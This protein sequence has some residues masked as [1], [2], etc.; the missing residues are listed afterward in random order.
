MPELPEVETVRRIF[1]RVLLGETIV[2][3]EI[4]EDDI[5]LKKTP[6]ATVKEAVLGKKVTA[7][8]RRGKYFWLELESKPW[9]FG[10][11]GMAGWVR[12][13]GAPT[14]RLREHGNAPF[15]DENGQ[16][17]FL[18]MGLESSNGKRLVMTDGRR[19]ARIW[20]CE[21]P[22]AD[23][24]I[25]LLSPDWYTDPMSP[26]EVFDRIKKKSAPMK[27]I[28]LD[29]SHFAGVGNWIADEV[30]YQ[31]RIR[32]D[33]LGKDL[34]IEETRELVRHL[35]NILKQAID[36]GADSEQFPKSWLFHYRW[37]GKKGDDL[38]EGREI[39][40]DQIGGR[41]TAWVPAIQ[42]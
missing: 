19:L 10:H 25:S 24:A 14:I 8:G 33:R 23:K 20:L 28:L 6:S 1:E 40:R 3:A 12:E 22:E 36:L 21:S 5:V 30:L 15:E 9:L 42:R 39:Q 38:I 41:T 29:Q 37:G 4:A 34:S 13:L 16:T 17:R 31:A 7:V 27:A 35:N 32:P 18:K 11:L 26:E 2:H